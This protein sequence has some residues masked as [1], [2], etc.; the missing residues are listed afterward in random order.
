[1]R[2]RKSVIT[3]ELFLDVRCEVLPHFTDRLQMMELG[4]SLKPSRNRGLFTDRYADCVL[5]AIGE[6][7]DLLTQAVLAKRTSISREIQTEMLKAAMRFQRELTDWK[8]FATW[9]AASAGLHSNSE[10]PANVRKE[11]QREL[12]MYHVDDWVFEVLRKIRFR[13]LLTRTAG[14]FSSPTPYNVVKLAIATI[15]GF[16]PKISHRQICKKLDGSKQPYPT[17]PSWAVKLR[18]KDRTWSGALAHKLTFNL[19][20]SYISKIKPI[21]L[22]H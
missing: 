7:S 9:F 5:A 12:V 21:R 17:P 8:L 2:R 6:F 16:N 19:V 13:S 15:K 10:I 3:R 20:K 1:M 4:L 14:G 18:G 22:R 11:L